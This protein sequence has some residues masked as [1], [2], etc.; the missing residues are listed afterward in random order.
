V[1]T[2]IVP[3]TERPGGSAEAK[4]RAMVR[5]WR[6][7]RL[8]GLTRLCVAVTVVVVLVASRLHQALVFNLGFFGGCLLTFVMSAREWAVPAY[9]KNWQTGAEGEKRTAKILDRLGPEWRVRHDLQRRYGN[10][11]HVLYGPAGVFLLDS[12]VWD[13]GVT[14]VTSAGPRVQA[15]HN[16]DLVWDWSALPGRMKAAA[17][18]L[19]E[20][21][22]QLGGRKVF[23]TPVVVIWG[24][25]PEGIQERQGVYYVA[26]ERLDGWLQA[27]P[28]RLSDVDRSVLARLHG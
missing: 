6:R 7:S 22:N 13:N 23:V 9:I 11:D 2:D 10:V 14:T 26:G 8:K 28:N 5:D 12:K 15:D 27:L 4:Y 3:G 16:P 21:M 18:A 25:Y 1:T 17:A 20:G 19:S 24:D